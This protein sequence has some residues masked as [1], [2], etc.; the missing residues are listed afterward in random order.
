MFRAIFSPLQERMRKTEIC[1]AHG[2]ML[3]W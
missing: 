1:T 3:L 2:I